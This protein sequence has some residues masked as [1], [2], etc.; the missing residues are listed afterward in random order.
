MSSNSYSYKLYKTNR[1]HK[2][3]HIT[4]Y[5]REQ[6]LEMTTLELRNICFKEKLIEGM[7]NRL[8]REEILQIILKFRS[9]DDHLL[10]S[11]Y[12]KGGFERVEAAINKYLRTPL[13][14]V[15]NISIPAR[16]TLYTGL[17]IGKLDNYRVEI[18][19][20]ITESNV[21]LVNE[22]DELCGILNVIEDGRKAG[23]FYLATEH[24]IELRKTANKNYSLLF[25]RKQD[26]DYVYKS[27]YQE[28]P[29]P[30]ANLYYCKVPISDLEIRELETTDA[31]L[32]IDFG[33]SS[34]TAGAY[35]DNRYISA[36]CDNDLL[37]GRVKLNS[38]NYVVFPEEISKGDEEWIEMLPTV[39]SVADC[40]DPTDVRFNVGY[41]ALKFA[42]RNGYSGLA[43]VFHGLKR[44][45]NHYEKTEEVMDGHGNTAVITRSDMLRAYMKV[46][47]QTAEH[48][49][50]CRFKYLHISS[51]VKMK[52]QFIQMFTKIL[53]EYQIETDDALDEG[54]AVLFNTI[55]NQIE[56]NSYLDGEEYKALVIDCGGGTTD[57]SSCS[58]SI[59][60]G[61]MSYR[62][63]IHTSYE[64]GDTNFGGNNITYRIM[65]FMKIVFVEYYINKR[66]VTDIDD[67]I[68]IPGTDIYRHVDEFGVGA[69]Y[70]QLELHYQAAERMLPTRF[71]QYENRTRDEYHRVRNNFYFLWE[72]A[73]E[74]KKEF[75]RKT[76][77]LRNRFNDTHAQQD[78]H[79]LKVTTIDRWTLS[80]QK[81]GKFIDV[82][83]FP[84]V[85]FTIKEINQLI[86]ADI[87]DVVRKF[88][89]EFY[90]DGSLQ[91]FSIIKLTGQSC[92]IDMFKEALKEFVPGRSIEF[93][94]KAEDGGKVPELKLACLRGVLR[95][96]SAKKA[97][98]IEASITNHA[99]VVPYSVTAFTHSRQEK[100]L[101][102][103]QEK[104]DQVYGY[105]SRPINVVEMEIYLKDSTDQMLHKY[106][107]TNDMSSYEAVL[108]EDIVKRFG[109]K[110]DQD[111]T[112][113]ITNG[114]VK[115][116]VFSDEQNWGFYV[117]P[118]ARQ[119]EQ[120]YLGEKTFFPFEND[121]SEL[122]FFDGLK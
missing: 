76:G 49:F 112:D 44:W 26:S 23:S 45:V 30:P 90:Q 94:Q 66:S 11:S 57:L 41:E 1:D 12:K 85:I 37:N 46:V 17:K 34:T 109:T 35:L 58:F 3:Q 33:T 72:L 91:Q 77:M 60:D 22:H 61:H 2:A 52:V 6:L 63:D 104:L 19:S 67:I 93:R 38:I 80:L 82:H 59:E 20:G 89:E 8:D 36:P 29:L 51:P 95:Y 87:Y 28:H 62:L 27:Y 50:K 84:D 111:D 65:Q 83:D 101:I 7:A 39:V 107:C 100:I 120:L 24:E 96:L 81:E 31:V 54:M 25:F 88:L 102:A 55:A 15:G 86:R 9:A 114:E 73:E 122:D 71:K 18:S 117:V 40:T 75:F 13:S 98:T 64:N 10:I 56:K 43:T 105:I 74:M 108:Y 14:D 70:E 78:D 106:V 53:H 48:Q 42:K 110:I 97:G 92:R 99:P 118:I 79:D 47:I 113:S 4:K 116:F 68:D 119:H 103:H 16:M 69:V 121:L 115:F 32:A 21:L 5:T